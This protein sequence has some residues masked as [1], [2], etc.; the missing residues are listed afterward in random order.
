MYSYGCSRYMRFKAANVTGGAARVLTA[1]SSGHRASEVRAAEVR[2]GE[3]RARTMGGSAVDSAIPGGKKNF[4]LNRS[5][6]LR[7]G[8]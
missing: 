2:A 8:Y 4:S 5:A 6:F 1:L 3:I 7:S